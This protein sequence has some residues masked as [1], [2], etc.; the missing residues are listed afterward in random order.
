MKRLSNTPRSKIRAA[1]RKLWLRCRERAQALKN[2]KY[3]CAR[4]GVKQSKARGREVRVEVHHKHG[5]NWE[6]MIDLIAERILQK[7]EDYE[8]LCE[9]CHDKEHEK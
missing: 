7:P 4:C 6:G 8:V 1:L 9:K 5:I 2:A 3:C